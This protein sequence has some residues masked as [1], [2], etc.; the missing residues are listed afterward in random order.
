MVSNIQQKAK[1]VTGAVGGV[2]KPTTWK[3]KGLRWS[4]GMASLLFIILM[5]LLAIYWSRT[6]GQ[7][8]VQDNARQL[9]GLVDQGA[10]LVPG[11]VTTAALISVSKTLLDKP[12]FS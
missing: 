8:D 10:K 4:I 9:V 7:F 2:L 3:E 11:S 1:I 6:P 5:L 12:G